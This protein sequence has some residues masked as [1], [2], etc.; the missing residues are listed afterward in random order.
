MVFVTKNY[1]Y[2]PE[3]HPSAAPVYVGI[4]EQHPS[5]VPVPVLFSTAGLLGDSR[6][7]KRYKNIKDFIQRGETRALIEVKIGPFAASLLAHHK[8]PW[9]RFLAGKAFEV[10]QSQVKFM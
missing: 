6:Q 4:L 10:S 7:T 5:A 1:V 9:P 2:I 3:Q 8:A